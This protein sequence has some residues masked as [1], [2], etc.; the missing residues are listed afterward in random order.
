MFLF[1]ATV[2]K[3]ALCLRSHYVPQ[4]SPCFPGPSCMADIIPLYDPKECHRTAS[5]QRQTGLS[6]FPEHSLCQRFR[7]ICAMKKCGMMSSSS[8]LTPS[9]APL[10][11][12]SSLAKSQSTRFS[13]YQFG[14]HHYHLRG[15]TTGRLSKVTEKSVTTLIWMKLVTRAL[16]YLCTREELCT[17]WLLQCL[18]GLT[19]SVMAKR[20][21]W[22]SSIWLEEVLWMSPLGN[23][24]V[25]GIM[26]DTNSLRIL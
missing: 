2:N 10:V 21:A 26:R 19:A 12:I 14:T 15:W 20:G 1:G 8:S 22:H 13:N 7:K 11:L 24:V 5:C 17:F 25:W 4:S 3:S 18:W 16:G 6:A 23:S 9:S